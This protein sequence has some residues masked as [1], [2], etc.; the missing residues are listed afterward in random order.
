MCTLAILGTFGAAAFTV[1]IFGVFGSAMGL[2]G[3]IRLELCRYAKSKQM[4]RSVW[5]KS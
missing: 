2:D 3:D 4:L 5:P 1:A